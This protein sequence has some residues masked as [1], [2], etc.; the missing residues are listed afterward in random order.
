MI[1][2]DVNSRQVAQL[3]LKMKSSAAPALEFTT[4]M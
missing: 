1:E 2:D 4:A 3:Q